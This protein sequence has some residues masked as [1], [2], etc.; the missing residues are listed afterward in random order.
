MLKRFS[1]FAVVLGLVLVVGGH[2]ALLQSVA[3]VGMTIEFSRSQP[4]D[5]AIQKTLDGQHPCNLCHFVSEGKKSERAQ[6]IVKPATKLDLIST[7]SFILPTPTEQ[8]ISLTVFS[9]NA[10]SRSNAP[11]SPPPRGA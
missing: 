3:W 10:S 7:P 2:W 5:K 9:A 4:I 8:P 6:E 1:R 11:P